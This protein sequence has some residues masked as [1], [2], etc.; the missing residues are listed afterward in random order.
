MTFSSSHP[1]YSHNPYALAGGVDG[2]HT[3]PM[4][5]RASYCHSPYTLP[6]LGGQTWEETW[7][8]CMRTAEPAEPSSPALSASS[9]LPSPSVFEG[10][11][12]HPWG[13]PAAAREE[14]GASRSG[15]PTNSSIGSRSKSCPGHRESNGCSSHSNCASGSSG[16]SP[17]SS[18]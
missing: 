8:V 9:G 6:H 18:R 2:R 5:D 1:S 12:R 10:A 3:L 14:T 11:G 4:A 13:A 15:S 17:P 7:S 16:G